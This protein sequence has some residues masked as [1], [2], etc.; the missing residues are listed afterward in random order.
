MI[1]EISPVLTSY[2]VYFNRIPERNSDLKKAEENDEMKK[3]FEKEKEKVHPIY[4]SQGKIIRY[5]N[6]RKLDILV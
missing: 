2:T 6:G 1:R 4:N 3:F 5:N